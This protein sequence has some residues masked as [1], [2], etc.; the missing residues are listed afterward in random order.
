MPHTLFLVH[1]PLCSWYVVNIGIL[2]KIH[3]GLEATSWSN[4]SATASRISMAC[5]TATAKCERWSAVE[6]RE[7][8]NDGTG[9]NARV[10][11]SGERETALYSEG[12][13]AVDATCW[14]ICNCNKEGFNP[15]RWTSRPSWSSSCANCTKSKPIDTRGSSRNIIPV[16]ATMA[17][18]IIHLNGMNDRLFCSRL[19]CEPPPTS[20]WQPIGG[21]QKARDLLC[22]SYLKTKL[23]QR[24]Q[25]C[26]LEAYKSNHP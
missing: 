12:V 21:G 11:S 25:G 14:G 4:I 6:T 22:K 8:Y 26:V 10:V 13:D 24:P 1:L 7:E 23:L 16:C 3:Q 2:S 18:L 19:W 20:E 17:S 5:F 15:N 9:I